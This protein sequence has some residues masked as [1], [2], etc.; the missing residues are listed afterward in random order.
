MVQRCLWIFCFHIYLSSC[1][2]TGTLPLGSS[3]EASRDSYLSSQMVEDLPAV[4]NTNYT[5]RPGNL[6]FL[7]NTIDKRLNAQFRVDADGILDLPYNIRIDTSD[8]TIGQL[9]S[10]L[11][12]RYSKYFSN[13]IDLK[14]WLRKK[15]QYYVNVQGKV[16]E[17]GLV[18]VGESQTLEEVIV[19]AGGLEGEET[20]KI[21]TMQRGG[22]TYSIELA[23]YFQGLS[24]RKG[25]IWSGGEKVVVLE[26]EP[27][28]RRLPA[29]DPRGISLLGDVATQ[30]TYEFKEGKGLY[31]Y[32]LVANGIN[33]SVDY[34]EVYLIRDGQEEVYRFSFDVPSSLPRLQPNDVLILKSRQASD[35]ES[36]LRITS[37][38]T[39]LLTSLLSLFL[40]TQ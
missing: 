22:K 6:V 11:T 31:Y 4:V 8:M 7:R 13:E 10:V 3:S 26:K 38:V 15:K 32:L 2:T 30:G 36:N 23:R 28:S 17:P 18:L 12:T 40:V 19:A 5:L 39:A 37:T 25:A 16:K 35:V 27:E 21:L 29:R 20:N 14:A 34:D 9:K 1:A 24:V 33:S